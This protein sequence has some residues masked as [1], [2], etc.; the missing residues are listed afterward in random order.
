[1][2][3]KICLTSINFTRAKIP[4]H[5]NHILQ[6]II[7][8][9][10]SP[11]LCLKLHNEGYKYEKR[12]FRLFTFSRI[13]SKSILRYN[14]SFILDTPFYFYFSSFDAK[15]SES[16]SIN[17]LKTPPFYIGGVQLA[18]SSVE[19]LPLP[20]FPNSILIKMLSPMTVYSTL[21]KPDG[22]K[23]TY[24]YNPIEKEFSELIKN[25]ALKKYEI[26]KNEEYRGK[27]VFEVVRFSIKRNFHIIKYKN[28]AI[29]S[30]SGL[31]KLEASEEMIKILYLC[32]LGAKNSQGFGMFDIYSNSNRKNTT[33][34]S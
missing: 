3:L 26:I 31:F 16:L 20:A 8:R 34:L 11:D 4:I 1:M 5:Y 2:K 14:D 27:F 9:N 19:V 6:G 12:Q 10:L 7:Y 23:K 13:F 25:N 24:F 32:G 22:Y 17:L 33:I 29:H 28:V 30:Y 18:I 21:S 15:V